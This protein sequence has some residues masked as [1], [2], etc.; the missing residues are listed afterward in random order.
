MAT[1]CLLG[2]EGEVTE[3][4]DIGLE[5]VTLGRDDTADLVVADAA[6]SRRHFTIY[7]E[8]EHYMLK[9][10]GSQNGTS[11][12]GHR[13]RETKL[14]QNDCILAGRTLFL[15]YEHALP[16]GSDPRALKHPHDT[17]FL[18]AGLAA[19]RAARRAAGKA[20]TQQAP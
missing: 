1:L 4:W 8:A 18:P 17:A 20:P 6:L 19:E 9:D 2:E 16:P 11:V 15:F 7:R 5:P 12:D 14:K 10:L 3:R 13:A